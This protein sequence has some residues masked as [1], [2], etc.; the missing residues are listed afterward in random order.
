VVPG[1]G[2]LPAAER[3]ALRRQY[4][5][6]ARQLLEKALRQGCQGLDRLLEEGDFEPLGHQAEFVEL[7]RKVP[8]NRRQDDATAPPAGEVLPAG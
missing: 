3:D 7:L 8:A 4:R 6:H 2:H 5:D 1:L